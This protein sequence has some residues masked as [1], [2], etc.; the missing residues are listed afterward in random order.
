LTTGD[1]HLAGDRVTT[2]FFAGWL[3]PFA[4]TCGLFAL[5]LFAFL[6]ATYLTVDARSEPDLQDDFRLRGIW[7]QIALIL[8]AIIVFITSENGAPLMY[9]GLTNWWA[10]DRARVDDSER[11]YRAPSALVSGVLFCADRCSGPSD[12]YSRRLGPSPISASGNPGYYYSQCRGTG[13]DTKALAAC[14]GSRCG[15]PV[16]VTSLPLPNL[17][18]TRTALTSAPSAALFGGA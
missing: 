8:L 16:A 1:I 12:F 10:P 4:L 3:T 18:R 6:A 5:A 13:I 7:A 14:S 11:D 15:G 17:Q 9:R 2:G